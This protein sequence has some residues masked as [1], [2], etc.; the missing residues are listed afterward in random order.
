MRFRSANLASDRNL[1]GDKANVAWTVAAEFRGGA[2]HAAAPRFFAG[3]AGAVS[4]AGRQRLNAV[5]C[6]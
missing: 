6:S 3:R 2:V 4:Q 5:E 1:R